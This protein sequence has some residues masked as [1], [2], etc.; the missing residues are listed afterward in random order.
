MISGAKSQYKFHDNPNC[1]TKKEYEMRMAALGYGDSRLKQAG[2][3]LKAQFLKLFGESGMSPA[4]I[5]KYTKGRQKK[6][7]PRVR[8]KKTHLR[9]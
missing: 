6:K 3:M 8:N 9:K 4:R 5:S 7:K 2:E 1:E